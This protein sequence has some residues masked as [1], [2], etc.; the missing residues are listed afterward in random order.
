MEFDEILAV[1]CL[2]PML[3]ENGFI[4]SKLLRKMRKILVFLIL[5]VIRLK[6]PGKSGCGWSLG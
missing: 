2:R 5:E 4:S 3:W 1:V 6:K